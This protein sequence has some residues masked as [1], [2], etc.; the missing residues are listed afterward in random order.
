MKKSE[1]QHMA[2]VAAIGCIACLNKG[3]PDTPATLHHIMSGTGMGQ[4]SGNFDVIPLC[5]FHHQHGKAGEAIHAGVQT[6]EKI[7][8]TEKALLEQVKGLIKI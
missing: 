6:W 5:P 4:R 1:R 8:G 2:K 3:Y 7:H